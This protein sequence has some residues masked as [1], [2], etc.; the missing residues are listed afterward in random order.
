MIKRISSKDNSIIKKVKQLGLKKYRDKYNLF[1]IEGINAINEAI[2]NHVEVRF[3][4]AQDTFLQEHD[5][6]ELINEIYHEDIPIFN[7]PDS[8]FNYIS[9]TKKPQGIIAVVSKLEFDYE[10]IVKEEESN[11]LILD[12]IQDP[13]NLGTIVR[14][15]DAAGIDL[16]IS[17]KGSVDFYL[18]KTVRSAA[19]S[20]FRIPTV[21][22]ESE[23]EVIALLKKHKKKLMVTSPRAEYLCYEVPL[24][25][26]IALV[27]GNEANGVSDPFIKEA[28]YMIKIPMLRETES[29]NASIA[30]SIVMYEMVRQRMKE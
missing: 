8:L 2:K 21:Q 9:E 20:I 27:I 11:I 12:K 7:V 28:E 15:A 24:Y 17:L 19:G 18:S 16:I 3:T 1:I 26:N 25:K 10:R 6:E 5:H 23:N 30:A 29:L 14:T 4:V 13:G 22:L